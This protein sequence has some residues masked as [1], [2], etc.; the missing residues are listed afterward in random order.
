MENKKFSHAKKLVLIVLLSSFNA[1]P[2]DIK[3]VADLDVLQGE[4]IYYRALATRNEAKN[5][6]GAEGGNPESTVSVNSV[7]AGNKTSTSA[8]PTVD[9]IMGNA[10]GLI[11][12]LRYMDGQTTTNR[13]GDVIN[14]NYKI[15]QISLRGVQ[16]ISL[17]DGTK[18]TLKDGS[19]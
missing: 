8:M 2:A 9:S 7:S 10:S 14:G 16:V 3:T 18:V 11:V 17:Q 12:R 6:A 13:A 1:W 15:S 19:N 4:A 5:K